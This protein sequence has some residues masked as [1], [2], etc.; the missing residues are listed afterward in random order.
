MSTHKKPERFKREG[1]LVI[2]QMCRDIKT[3][4]DEEHADATDATH[5][6]MPWEETAERAK[7]EEAEEKE[8]KACQATRTVRRLIHIYPD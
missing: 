5:E 2:L 7:S 1:K 8:G 3:G 6:D 4:D